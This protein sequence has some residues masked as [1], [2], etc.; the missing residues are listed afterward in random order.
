M[1]VMYLIDAQDEQYGEH[2]HDGADNDKLYVGDDDSDDDHEPQ[3]ADRRRGSDD[4][5]SSDEEEDE[6]DSCQHHSPIATT[7]QMEEA[8]QFRKDFPTKLKIRSYDFANKEVDTK[9]CTAPGKLQLHMKMLSLR[10][11]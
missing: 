2:D 7:Q 9:A 1:S 10:C 11:W 5:G 6:A 4:D 3:H 8:E